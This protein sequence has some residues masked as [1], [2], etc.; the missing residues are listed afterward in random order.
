M[1]HCIELEHQTPT[2]TRVLS[3][4]R[5]RNRKRNHVTF[6]NLRRIARWG[7]DCMGTI[8]LLSKKES[9]GIA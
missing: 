4:F 8:M 3:D 5:I 7:C 1:M 2:T 6:E 9:Y